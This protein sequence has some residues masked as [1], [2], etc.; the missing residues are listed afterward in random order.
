M[1]P[2]RSI[3]I[4]SLKAKRDRDAAFADPMN[5]VKVNKAEPTGVKGL[6]GGKKQYF[7]RIATERNAIADKKMMM[8]RM[9]N[10]A[11]NYKDFPDN[12]S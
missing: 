11:S 3:Y 10:A 6:I 12:R 5:Q 4:K 1:A 9:P 8:N 2:S 7:D